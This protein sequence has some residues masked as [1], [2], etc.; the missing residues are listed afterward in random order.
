MGFIRLY[1]TIAAGDSITENM[2]MSLDDLVSAGVDCIGKLEVRISIMDPET[3]ETVA[4]GDLVEVRTSDYDADWEARPEG[5]M[6]Y[7]TN[8]VGIWFLGEQQEEFWGE[9]YWY[10]V[11]YMENYTDKDLYID[12]ESMS[13]N[14]IPMECWVGTDVGPGRRSVC[15]QT[16]YTSDFEEAEIDTVKEMTVEFSAMDNDEWEDLFTTGELTFS[17]ESAGGVG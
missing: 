6:I 1:D 4:M 14:G 3:W 17:V 7:D 13:L 16:F 8:S 10:Y 11:F 2:Y 9:H 15:I 12:C 5:A